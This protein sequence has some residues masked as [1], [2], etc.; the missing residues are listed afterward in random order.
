[1]Y[2]DKAAKLFYDNG[3]AVQPIVGS[4]SIIPKDDDNQIY[5]GIYNDGVKSNTVGF[6]AADKVEGVVLSDILY[7]NVNAVVNGDK[8]VDAWYAE[9]LDAIAKF[10]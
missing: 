9:V 8:T 6:A 10:N 4:D 1:M 2:T 7:E 3:G 5:F